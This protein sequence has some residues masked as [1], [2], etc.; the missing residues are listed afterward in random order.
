M[1]NCKQCEKT[2]PQGGDY[3]SLRCKDI[4]TRIKTPRGKKK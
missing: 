2:I 4:G 3:C 1:T